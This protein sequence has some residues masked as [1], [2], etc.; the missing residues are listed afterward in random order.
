M[1]MERFA[2]RP[3][4][5]REFLAGVGALGAGTLLAACSSGGSTP[6]PTPVSSGKAT[7]DGDLTIFNWNE[8]LSPKVVKSF[9]QKYGVKANL[10]YYASEDE[11]ISKLATH[12]PYDVMLINSTQLPRVVGAGL[13]RK[14]DHSQVPHLSDMLSFFANPPYDPHATYTIPYTA[15]AIGIIWRDDKVSGMTGSIQD[16]WTHNDVKGHIF[17]LDDME[18][19]MS[20]GLLY[21][22]FDVNTTNASQIKA[23]GDALIALKPSLGGISSDDITMDNNQAWMTTGAAGDVFPYIES[24]PKL[25]DVMR[26]EVCKEG[27]M[28]SA[29]TWAIPTAAKHPGTATLFLDWLLRPESAAANTNY[30]GYP[31]ATNSGLETY[32]H[33]TKKYPF[34]NIDS[35][36]YENPAGWI[37]GATGGR[38]QT[39]TTEWTL[40][41]AA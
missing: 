25:A 28:L 21:K 18:Y 4:G 8:Y 30:T 36:I 22:G 41:K 19:G 40:F 23:A 37:I 9:E 31:M 14:V 17:L 20:A 35:S 2:H 27:P 3:L 24:N 7:V 16:L 32:N 38:L 13:L 12:L 10:V 6:T 26:F 1:A 5:R 39:L 15:G 34:L 11:A 33:L 29:D